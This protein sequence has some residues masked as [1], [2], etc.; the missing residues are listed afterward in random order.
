MKEIIRIENNICS[1]ED[2][3]AL[4]GLV[5]AFDEYLKKNH[6]GFIMC[7]SV[8][9]DSTITTQYG[10][11]YSIDYDTFSWEMEYVLH[12]G[13]SENSINAF[14][15]FCRIYDCMNLIEIGFRFHSTIANDDGNITMNVW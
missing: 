7:M 12:S 13:T 8:N 2:I 3:D 1:S 10:S 14:K 11:T 4:H 15:R 6:N 5:S 9:P